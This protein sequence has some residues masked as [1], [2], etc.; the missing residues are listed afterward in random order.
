MKKSLK[1]ERILE[2]LRQSA[3]PLSVA[4]LADIAVRGGELDPGFRPSD[5][6]KALRKLVEQRILFESDRSGIA[7]YSLPENDDRAVN[8]REL[9]EPLID[10][11]QDFHVTAKAIPAGPPGKSLGVRK[12]TYP[13]VVGFRDYRE[14]TPLIR[15]LAEATGRGTVDLFSYELKQELT[16][17]NVRDAILECAANSAWANYGYV[18]APRASDEALQEFDVFGTRQGVGFILL[19]V[20]RDGDRLTFDSDSKVVHECPRRSADLRLI[21]R[22]CEDFGWKPFR[23]WLEHVAP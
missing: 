9:D 6:E 12:W 2:I 7:E 3:S 8:E 16:A 19:S 10:W 22:M 11:L 20:T 21:E 17:R 5:I 23:D 13:D 1:A 18:V 15:R 4:R 14:R